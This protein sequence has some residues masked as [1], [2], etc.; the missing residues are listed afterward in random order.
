MYNFLRRLLISSG[1]ISFSL[2]IKIILITKAL[3]FF[4]KAGTGIFLGLFM[5]IPALLG[6]VLAHPVA[7]VFR[8]LGDLIDAHLDLVIKTCETESE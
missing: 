2:L 7:I 4:A 6:F 1:S 3:F 8:G 5:V